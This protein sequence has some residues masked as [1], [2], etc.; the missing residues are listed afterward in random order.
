[1][2][3]HDYNRPFTDLDSMD[4]FTSIDPAD[5]KRLGKT[6]RTFKITNREYQQRF[7]RFKKKNRMKPP[8]GSNT[9]IMLGNLVVRKLGTKNQYET[10]L[11]D[12]VIED[13]YEQKKDP[14][15]RI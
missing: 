1:M 8:P 4:S 6:V 15:G 2:S 10:W 5:A 12:H 7:D 11:P 3:S 13:L 9:H 14:D